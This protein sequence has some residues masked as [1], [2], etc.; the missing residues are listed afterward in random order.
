MGD[1]WRATDL[2][3]RR[4]VAVKRANTGDREQIRRE[5]R[6]GAGLQHPNVIAVF[7]AVVEEGEDGERWLVM[8]YLPARSMGETLRADGPMPAQRAAQVGAQVADALSAMHAK[9]MVHRDITPGNILVA[10][11][12]TAKLADLGIA[13]WAEVTLTGTAESPGTPGYVAP[14]LLKGVA[15]TPAADMYALGVTLAAAVEGGG[16]GSALAGV[17]A[18]MTDPEPARRPT[19]DESARRL[20]KIAGT[21]RSRRPFPRGLL[22]AAGVVLVGVLVAGVLVATGGG[23]DPDDG[24]AADDPSRRAVPGAP[25]GGGAELLYGLG[26][27]ADAARASELVQDTPTWMLTTWYHKPSDL[28]TLTTWRESVVPDAYANGYALGLIVANWLEDSPEVPIE[29]KYGRACGRSAPLTPDFL[30]HMRTLA[31]TFAGQADGPPLYVTV[32]HEVSAMA[33]GHDGYY[34]NTPATTAYYRAL[35]DRYL[36]IRDIFHAEA[37]NARVALGWQ[38]WQAVLDDYPDTAGGP[39]MFAEFADVLAASDFQSI[40]TKQ[41]EGNVEEVR[42]SVE[43]LGEYGPVMVAAYADRNVPPEVVDEDLRTLFTEESMADLT[44]D[45]L[46]A[47]NFNRERS[48]IEAGRPTYDFVK[49]VVRGTGSEVR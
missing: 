26:G 49:E 8:E 30:K 12:G 25:A 33:C 2:E 40:V 11:D 43:I 16:P 3:L 18:A 45:G 13:V 6:I 27:G 37:P 24:S 5:A 42:R 29:T 46:F 31:R 1:V 14:E 34:A 7:D 15:A 28:P 47:W 36:E 17:L 20:R 48:L 38:G 39:S 4:V 32:F 41:P 10:D 9:G 35:K 44:A 21:A 22:A 19:A 23:S